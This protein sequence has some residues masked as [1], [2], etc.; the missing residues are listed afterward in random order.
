MKRKKDVLRILTSLLLIIM[1]A[2]PTY[3]Q[4]INGL[5]NADILNTSIKKIISTKRVSQ[6]LGTARGRVIS[7]ASLGISNDNNGIISVYAE[8]LCHIPVEKIYMSIYLEVWDEATQDWEYVNDYEYT[9]L[10]SERPN[11]DLTDVSVSFDVVGLPKGKTYSL[12]GYHYAKS[13]GQTA[14]IMTTETDGIVLK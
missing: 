11:V 8:T 5:E 14:E 12:R 6:V 3:A 7:S 4:N 10:A 13:A 2:I 9:W 1:M